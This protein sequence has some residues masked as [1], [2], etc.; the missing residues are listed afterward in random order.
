[1]NTNIVVIGFQKCGT[2]AFINEIASRSNVVLFTGPNGHLEVA[3]PQI[4]VIETADSFNRY[5]NMILVHKFA[6]YY[7][8]DVAL[9]YLVSS[10]KDRHYVLFIRDLRKILVSWHKMHSSIALKGLLKNHFAYLERDFYSNCVLRDYYFK[11]RNAFRHDIFFSNILKTIPVNKLI[12]VSQ[13]FLAK[14]IKHATNLI[15]GSID[16]EDES[17]IVDAGY[18]QNYHGYADDPYKEVPEDI[19]KELNTYNSAL[20][21]SVKNSGARLFL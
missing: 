6:A 17:V 1:M 18:D 2:T 4:Q 16:V 9:N 21:N 11:R 5:K 8:N 19:M 3:W 13:E 7:M 15:L 12:V 14:N 20:I 10:N